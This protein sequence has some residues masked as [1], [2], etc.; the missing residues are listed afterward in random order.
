M[1]TKV[2]QNPQYSCSNFNKLQ[3]FNQKLLFLLPSREI[4]WGGG[5]F[6]KIFFILKK[7]GF[8]CLMLIFF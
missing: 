7:I 2:R 1:T 5:F 4:Y 3:K 8:P 6:L